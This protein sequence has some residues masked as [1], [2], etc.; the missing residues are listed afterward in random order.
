MSLAIFLFWGSGCSSSIPKGHVE[1]S[2]VILIS[3][4]TL[5]A[6]H[7]SCY[8]YHRETS[9]F[10]DGLAQ[11]G[12]RFVD[13]RSPS[14]WT[15]P[16][17][18]TMMTGLHPHHH[19]V[20]DDSV[21]RDEKTKMLAEVMK[22]S[23][24]DTAGIVS[25][26]YVSSIFG[27]DKGFDTFEDFSLHTEKANLSGGVQASDVVDRALSWWK[28]REEG[29]PVFLFLHFYDAHYAYEPPKPYNTMFDR[30]SK[31][32]DLRYRNYFHFK[33]NPPKEKDFEHLI[34]QYDESIRYIDDQISRLS[35]EL[36]GRSIRWVITSD[37]GEEFGERGSW[38]H[39]HTLYHEQLHIPFII[40]GAGISKRE[41]A[42]RVG[43][44][45]IMP[46]I[47]S[48]SDT[49]MEKVDGI[50]V[51]KE[52]IPKRVFI[53]ETSRFRSCRLS[54]ASDGYRLEWDLRSRSQELFS[55]RDFLETEDLAEQYPTVV[56]KLKKE[57]MSTIGTR[58]KTQ[59]EGTVQGE[60]VWNGAELSFGNAHLQQGAS[61][62]VFPFD[63]SF[64]FRTQKESAVFSH[65]KR[66]NKESALVYLGAGFVGQ[67][68][69]SPNVEQ[70]LQK[71]G[72]IQED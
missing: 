59:K 31:K 53:A 39:A 8:G 15:L 69:L 36:E 2:D 67:K 51:L 50:D 70:Q 60:Y 28:G 57:A 13:A 64:V 12:M 56:S 44:E 4:D 72:Y 6:D 37:H 35:T 55:D 71:L 16:T 45:D 33:K 11:K 48:W 27:F 54:V 18:T 40:S 34:A 23:G 9:P 20:V 38:G 29:K 46:T 7:L 68:A 47:S 19:G 32:G 52:V 17:H 22:D 30:E 66:P 21:Q 14:P 24:Y 65:A 61:F 49:S 5:R 1:K 41:V 3:I 62:T 10:I 42:Q 25:S 43:T 63:R 26:L 58:W